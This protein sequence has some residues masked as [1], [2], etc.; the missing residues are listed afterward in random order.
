MLQVH[1]IHSLLD[2]ELPLEVI[3]CHSPLSARLAQVAGFKAVWVSSLELSALNGLPDANF[4]TMSE[5]L[6][7]IQSICRSVSIPVIADCDSGYGNELNVYR[8]TQLYEH[9]GVSGIC[10]EDNVFPKKCSFYEAGEEELV[11][12]EEHARK[13]AAACK[14][15]RSNDFFIMA[16]TEAFIRNLGLQEALKRARAYA[17]A[18][19]D[20]IVVH[21]KIKTDEEIVAFSRAWD[22]DIPLVCIPTTYNQ[23]SSV[24]LLEKGYKIVIF[25]NH[26]LRASVS[27]MQA[28][29]DHI[30]KN[31]SSIG[32]DGSIASL[33]EVFRLTGVP[34]MERLIA[35]FQFSHD[36]QR[37]QSPRL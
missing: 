16:R 32:L 36:V 25:A 35:S 6:S 13:I 27:A 1:S 7:V 31:R 18:G 11:P 37:V 5:N 12:M 24:D 14:G 15:R 30:K 21:S 26:G 19:A 9:A 22:R 20:A 34:E 8:M 33:Q 23:Y 4:L 3:G 2:Q 29:F 10:I 17:D 28:A